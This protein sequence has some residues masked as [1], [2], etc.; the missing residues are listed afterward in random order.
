MVVKVVEE[1]EMVVQIVLADRRSLDLMGLVPQ[2]IL[3]V[4][5]KSHRWVKPLNEKSRV[6]LFVFELMI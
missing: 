4:V 2:K 1:V 5:V 6:K 3:D